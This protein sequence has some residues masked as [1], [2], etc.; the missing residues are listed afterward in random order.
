MY[1]LNSYQ[2]K[3]VTGGTINFLV[4]T[5][6]GIGGLYAG[7]NDLGFMNTFLVSTASSS[8]AGVILPIILGEPEAIVLIVPY[9]VYTWGIEACGLY[10]VGMLVDYLINN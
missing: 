9:L 2:T 1:Q 5:V 10:P 3:Q 7:Y 6:Y 8:V 4:S